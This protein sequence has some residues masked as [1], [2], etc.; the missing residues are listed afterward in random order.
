MTTQNKPRIGVYICHCGMNI[1]PKVDVEEV[2][3]YI[4]DAGSCH[5]CP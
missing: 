3:R 1:A 4:Q 5:C 2:A